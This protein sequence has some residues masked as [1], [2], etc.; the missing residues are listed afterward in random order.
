MDER[1][2]LLVITG[3]LGSGKTTLLNHWLKER[4]LKD[5]A[6]VINEFG[7]VGLDGDF[8]RHDRAR[9]GVI[10]GGCFCCSLSDSFETELL[11]V[12][13]RVTS[14]HRVDHLVVELSGVA[15]PMPFL[16]Y[17]IGNPVASRMFRLALVACTVDA[18]FGTRQ[19]ID[20]Q[21]AIT[22]VAIADL[23]VITK[24]DLASAHESALV[25]ERIAA[26]NPSAEIVEVANG[27]APINLTGRLEFTNSP[28]S[29][30]G[31]PK[32]P[33]ETRSHTQHD[34]RHEL[35]AFTLFAETPLEWHAF[36]RWLTTVKVRWSANLLRV[37]GVLYLRNER[38][39]R[40]IHGVHHVF[41]R[42][43]PLPHLNE[44][45][46]RSRLVFITQGLRASDLE[47]SWDAL[48]ASVELPLAEVKSAHQIGNT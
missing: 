5:S 21:E 41:H 29:P 40:A 28:A 9:T 17:V 37:K 43:T 30:N 36:R 42:P 46:R 22:Q 44:P 16:E 39:P 38:I 24:T 8:V 11:A 3:F 25:R 34:H 14:T 23:L 1:V 35:S 18:V 7:E 48:I 27:K 19:L 4:S 32:R 31:L 45:E 10:A 20:R 2:P 12:Y 33:L 6:V 47:P 13:S 26:L 15:D